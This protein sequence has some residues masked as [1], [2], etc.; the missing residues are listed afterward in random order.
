MRKRI[1]DLLSD[2]RKILKLFA[3]G[4]LI[5]F[6]GIGFIQW[7]DKLIEPSLKQESYMLLGMITGAMGFSISMIAQCFLIIHRFKSM[8]KKDKS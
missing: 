5:F 3:L 2:Q 1:A 8:G 7:A 4:A 6:I